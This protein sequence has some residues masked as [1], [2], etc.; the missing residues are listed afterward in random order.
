M[1]E[2]LPDF[3]IPR[4]D[5]G[6]YLGVTV[7]IVTNNQDPDGLGRI[8]VRLPWLSD[9]CESHWARVMTPMAGPERGFYFLP[10]VD[11]EVLV[12]FEHGRID[13]PYVLGALWN[14]KDKPPEKGSDRRVIKSRSGHLIV[15]DDTDGD[16]KIL[17]R[18]KT[19]KNEIT[20]LSKENAISVKCNGELT[21]EAQGK[22][23]IKS[24]SGDVL[25]NGNNI[26]LEAQQNLSSQA[27]SGLAIKCPAGVKINDG[28]LEVV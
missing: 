28:A 18:D 24:G 14:G 16:E 10:E 22:I 19:G 1:M 6:R 27:N 26:S 25:I 11:D 12:A 9:E 8:K 23:S 17:V 5:N 21:L 3:L 4:K 20:I 2:M 15:L 7:G 13:S